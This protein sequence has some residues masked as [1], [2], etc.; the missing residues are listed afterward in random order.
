M[1]FR[2]SQK[3]S[4][5]KSKDS[6]ENSQDYGKSNLYTYDFRKAKANF[7]ENLNS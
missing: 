1:L 2:T 5:D 4:N 7:K 6:I 3:L